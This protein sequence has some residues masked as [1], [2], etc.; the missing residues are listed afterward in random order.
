MVLCVNMLCNWALSLFLPVHDQCNRHWILFEPGVQFSAFN[1]VPQIDIQLK[2]EVVLR[3]V[4]SLFLHHR[5][6]FCYKKGQIWRYIVRWLVYDASSSIWPYK[7]R[8]AYGCTQANYNYN[9]KT[10]PPWLKLKDDGDALN[11]LPVEPCRIDRS[12]SSQNLL[13]R[14]GQLRYLC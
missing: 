10:S 4:Y 14:Y 13:Q 7:H 12:L 8:F 5:T 3:G 6:C 1:Q 2:S 9:K 11:F